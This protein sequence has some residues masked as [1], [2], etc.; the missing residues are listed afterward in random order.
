MLAGLVLG[1]MAFGV[2]AELRPERFPVEAVLSAPFPQ[3]I[4]AAPSADRL[5]FV[6]NER[7]AR[8]VWLAEGPDYRAHRLTGYVADDGIELS[9]LSFSPDGSQVLYVRGAAPNA[10]GELPNPASLPQGAE[11]ALYRVPVEG[12]E[13]I[14]IDDGSAPAVH[15]SGES[16]AYV[17]NGEVW[18]TSILGAGSEPGRIIS[19]RGAFSDLS[20]SPDGSQL[21]FVSNRGASSYVGVWTPPEPG[22]APADDAE[23]AT[24]AATD[25]APL[26]PDA[27]YGEIRWLSPALDR[28]GSPVWSPDGRSI[29]FLRLPPRSADRFPFEPLRTDL[30]FSIRLANVER[31]TSREIWRAEPG[32]GS[33][34]RVIEAPTQIFWGAGDQIVFAWERTG[35]LQLYSVPAMGGSAQ[36]LTSGDF[37]VEF[38]ALAPDRRYVV[39]AS[40]QDDTE[41][42][43]L[44][45]VPVEGGRVEPLTSGDGI[46]WAPA[47]LASGDLGLLRSD[48]QHPARAAVRVSGGRVRDLAPETIPASFPDRLVKPQPVEITATDG[49]Q[50][51]G[52]LFLPNGLRASQKVPAVLFLHGGSRRQMLLGWHKRAYY[53]NA[54]GMS[55][56]LASRG[57]VALALNYRSGI[58]YGLEFREAEDYGAAGASEVRDVLGA[59]LFLRDLPQVDPERIGVWGG[60]YGGFLTAQALSQASDLFSVGVD[61][62]GVHD[63]NEGI[64]IFAPGYNAADYP[65]LWVRAR[66]ASP[67][68]HLDTWRSPVL[69]IHGDDDRNVFFFQSVRLSRALRER[70]VH[71]ED[72]V[73]PDEVHSFMLHRNWEAAFRATAE[74]LLRHLQQ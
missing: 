22:A 39:F 51:S 29:A 44:W 18:Q 28:D 37:E 40:N 47:P 35:W 73:F 31:G 30:P 56:Y 16:V 45:R 4:V 59:G 38:V 12:G 10:A 8:N 54:Y 36:P 70:G 60:S 53:H 14:R 2:S 42:R 21:A 19:A 63:W 72:L 46:E 74:F 9:D 6:L 49:M 62:H 69:L 7:G 5:A 41:R 25:T 68:S 58:G 50:V 52:Q 15:P 26:D 23:A 65:K 34:Y 13:P 17:K 64:R 24:A 33:A 1:C 55:Q 3:E 27:N 48:A 71:V 61:M 11:L 43:H 32:R 67:V 57:V 66:A 20:W